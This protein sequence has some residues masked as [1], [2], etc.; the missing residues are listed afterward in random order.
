MGNRLKKPNKSKGTRIKVK[1]EDSSLSSIDY[2]IFCLKYLSRN[3]G[4]D[5]CDNEEKAAFA[6]QLHRLSQVTWNVLS[7]SSRH[8]LGW[9][10][11]PQSNI[12]DAIPNHVTEDVTFYAFRFHGLKPFL[13]YR[14]RFIF[15]I[16]FIDRNFTL[17]NHG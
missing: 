6:S 11:I 13:G 3:F 8:G 2:P 1:D 5:Q 16:L 10:K 14:N 9:E 4:L 12:K 17:Y 15:H 7:V